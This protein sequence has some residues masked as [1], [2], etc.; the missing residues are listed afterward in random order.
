MSIAAYQEIRNN[1]LY[2]ELVKRRRRLSWS[3]AAIV[4][5]SF[6]TFVL[7][8][9][10]APKLLATP[11][12]EGAATTVAVPIGVAMI[13]VYWVLTGVYVRRARRDFDELKNQIVS[14]VLK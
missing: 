8:V 7:L 14:E 3:L 9:A 2:P 12:A 13:V 6:F 5:V 4:L 11:V 1:K 10:F